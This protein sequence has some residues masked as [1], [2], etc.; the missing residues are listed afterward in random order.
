MFKSQE[1]KNKE[2]D[3]SKTSENNISFYSK[4]NE[5]NNF[6]IIEN[7]NKKIFE[8]FHKYEKVY[9]N[10]YNKGKKNEKYSS[11]SKFKCIYCK[12]YFRNIYQFEIHMKIHVSHK[13]IIL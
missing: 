10:I 2:T 11:S 13:Y 5:Q 4:L 8:I 3:L 12:K 1:K 7:E 9:F 6:K